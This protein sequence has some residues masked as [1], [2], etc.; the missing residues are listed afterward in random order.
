MHHAT[1]LI[2]AAFALAAALPAGADTP[3]KAASKVH[4]VNLKARAA[5]KP[6][7]TPRKETTVK[8][9]GPQEPVPAEP[10]Y[11]YASCGCS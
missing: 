6:A 4:A 2:I 3:A 8:M 10:V 9:R 5:T 1:P 11:D 7:A